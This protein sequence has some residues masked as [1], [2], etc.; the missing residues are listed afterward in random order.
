MRLRDQ[1]AVVTGGGRGIGRSIALAFARE[2][3]D[4]AVAARSGP[5]VAAVRR[6][7]EG[8]GRRG[9]A[10]VCDV[11]DCAQV[12]G[13]VRQVE[14]ALGPITIL[15][16]SNRLAKIPP[17]MRS[18]FAEGLMLDYYSVTDLEAIA[19]RDAG[20]GL[21]EGVAG[22]LAVNAGGEPRKVGHLLRALR[23]VLDGRPTAAMEDARRALR[24][25]GLRALGLSVLQVRY[26]Q[27]L[28]A[29]PEG[30]MGLNTLAGVLGTD[31]A[32]IAGGI[33]PFC[34]R[35]GLSQVTH[36][37]RAITAAGRTYLERLA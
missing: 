3:A 18:R 26:L 33:E 19:T 4:V 10:C 29:A 14:E 24:L 21:E 22:F 20:V 35:T 7:V 25:S 5:E 37:G 13:L 34:L 23:N 8:L 6:M 16:S 31:A 30:V 32:E 12:A 27:T 1:V 17:A 28:A 15:A 9:L 11:T 36:H 2:G